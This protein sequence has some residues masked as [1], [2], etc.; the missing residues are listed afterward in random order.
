[1][2]LVDV[3][4]EFDATVD[5]DLARICNDDQKAGSSCPLCL[6][7]RYYSGQPVQYTCSQLRYIYVLR[8]LPV[9]IKENLKILEAL[10]AKGV[11]NDWES[12]VQ[13]LA[14]GGGP[15]S[16]IAALQTFVHENGFFGSDV[17]E[18]HVTR[19]DRVKEWSEIYK[20]VRKISKGNTTKYKYLRI[21]D[22]VCAVEKYKGAYDLIFLSYIVSEL[23][24]EK[25]V[26]LGMALS[27]VAK[28]S[29]LLVFNDRNEQAVVNRIRTIVD[30]FTV[31][32]QYVSTTASHVG[33]NYPE[34]IKERVRPKLSLSSYRRGVVVAP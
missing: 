9:H 25:A 19:L 18:I 1:M 7:N 30:L 4:K 2:D 24:D 32:N 34:D 27:R 33:M 23:T 5:Y 12:P 11:E 28:E 6:K 17:P 13:V 22:D 16:E 10:N 31:A 29:C 21:N 26:R 15:G 14:L 8:Y 3:L 20:T